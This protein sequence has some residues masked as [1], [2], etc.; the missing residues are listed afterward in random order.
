MLFESNTED[1]LTEIIDVF[2]PCT[3]VAG[4]VV[5]Q[6]GESGDDFYVVETGDLSITIRI[7]DEEDDMNTIDNSVNE[8]KV[9]SYQGG[10]AFGEL[11]LI[12]GSP[13]AA[14]IVATEIC[15][16]WRIKRGWYRGVVGQH[17]QRLHKEKM[18]FLPKVSVGNQFLKDILK[19]D[20]LDTMAQLLKQEYFMKGDAI[21]R[22]GEAGNT[23][24]IIQ[25][26]EVNIFKRQLG[27]RPIATLGK[28]KFFG[29]KALLGDDVR[30]ATV[31]AAR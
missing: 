19:G 15:K 21:L 26:G 10:S 5:I 14:T 1:E 11:A 28:E 22:E 17:R 31:V 2:E 13:R 9:G 27:D 4:E 29:E 3:F 23:F 18:E 8:V 12:Y 20:Q 24:Y 6:Q 7:A 16:L 25:S 30:Q